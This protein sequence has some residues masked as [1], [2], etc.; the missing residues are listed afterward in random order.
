M[1]GR[2]MRI[3]DYKEIK[4]LKEIIKELETL[5]MIEES[6]E[7]FY[8]ERKRKETVIKIHRLKSELRQMF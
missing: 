8:N 3:S 7:C 1:G 6:D 5:Y 4:R 2:W